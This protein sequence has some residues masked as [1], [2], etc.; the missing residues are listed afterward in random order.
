MATVWGTNTLYIHL[1][2]CI[3]IIIDTRDI[4]LHV[5]S[6]ITTLSIACIH[7]EILKNRQPLYKGQNSPIYI[8]CNVSLVRRFH[9]N[10]KYAE[11]CISSLL[12]CSL[13][14]KPS[15]SCSQNYAHK[16][17]VTLTLFSHWVERLAYTISLCWLGN[18]I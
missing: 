16:K 12:T 9:C 14:P 17:M 18:I 13:V 2:T 5:R 4:F 11:S 10:T 1:Y 8:V 6:Y 3:C 7:C 15:P